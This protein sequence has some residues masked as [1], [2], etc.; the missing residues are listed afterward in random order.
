MN[1]PLRRRW[2]GVKLSLSALAAGALIAGCGGAAAS[3]APVA[4]ARHTVA[5]ASCVG[6][7]PA[8]QFA[9]ARLVFVGRMLPGPST[10]LDRPHVLASPATVR[11]LR[12]LKGSGPTT[13]KVR[14]AVTITNRGV[15]VAED[16]I[17]PQVGEIWKIYTGSRRQPLDTSICG[18]STM[19]RSAVRVA[20]DLWSGFPVQARPRPTIPLGEGVVLDPSSGFPDEDAKQAYEEHRF[21]LRAALPNGP[22]EA[23]PF[24]VISATEAYHRLRITG[25]SRGGTVPPLVV[26]AVDLETAMFAT[27]RGRKRL[28]AWQFSFKRVAK[29]ASVLALAP[30]ELFTPPRLEQL[31]PTGTGTSIEDAATA[32]RTGTA[33]T[34]SFNGAS[35]GN[36]PCDARYT[37]SAVAN[38]RAVAFTINTITTP[39]PPNTFC[40]AVGYTRSVVLHL[41]KPLGARVLISSS[42]GGAIPVRATAAR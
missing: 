33:I 3:P 31:G 11:V 13:V 21:V 18:G 22:A 41:A 12:Y 1:P 39:S 32:D 2:V 42:D 4:A 40:S 20:L 17:E 6:G 8:Q 5:A 36:K 23:G 25:R 35:S 16:G 9:M 29:P 30:A 26:R 37:A 38:R 14:T 24:R 15:T 27:D 10:S 19:L 7:S 34:V 28:P